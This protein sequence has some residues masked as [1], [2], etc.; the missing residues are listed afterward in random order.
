MNTIGRYIFRIVAGAFVISL[1][2]LTGVV[3][4]TQALREIDLITTK[5]QT[6][7]L[8][9]YMTVLALPALIMVIAPVALFIA[10]VYALNRINADSELVVV[11]AAGA[12]P[13]V[14]YKPFIILGLIV[15]LLTGSISLVVMPESARALRSTIANIRADVLTYI[16]V[17]GLFTSVEQG[18]T[19]HIR[20]R[21]P[22]GTLLGLLVNDERNPARMMTYLAE[23][24][25]IVRTGERAYLVMLNGSMQQQEGSPEEITVIRF[26][27]YVFDLSELTVGSGTVEY[28][29]RE[30][31]MSELLSPNPEDSYYQRFPG[32]FRAEIHERLSSILYPLAFVFISLATLGHPR[33]NRTGRG[34][35][36]LV[37]II[38]VSALRTV[39]FGASNLAARE[40]WAVVPMYALP[41]AAIVLAAWM[42]FGHGRSLTRLLESLPNMRLG[43]DDFTW[44]GAMRNIRAMAG[45]V[46]RAVQR[47]APLREGRAAR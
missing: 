32:K 21:A 26:D 1:A 36:I 33:T 2:V 13:K 47:F 25:R 17:E 44:S 39:G 20:A 46:A 19:F 7:W 31:R 22:D 29:P 30:M 3:W 8:F 16:V 37:A 9:L 15:T 14:I 41:A 42:A 28:R 45:A 24:G 43:A 38:A 27:R 10:C 40:A 5:G 34:H 18:L 4:V 11:N 35:S 23:E 6:L 12:S